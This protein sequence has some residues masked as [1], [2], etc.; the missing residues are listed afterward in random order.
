MTKKAAA[1]DTRRKETNLD[2]RY[3]EIGIPAVAAALRYQSEAKNPVG[4]P[5]EHPQDDHE[6][7][8]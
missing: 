1:Q 6:L 4:A 8:A 3:G 2:S 7:A 5:V